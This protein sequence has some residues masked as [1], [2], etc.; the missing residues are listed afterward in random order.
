MIDRYATEEMKKIWNNENKYRVWLKVEL[1]VLKAY[2]EKGIIPKD[3]YL[4]IEKRAK[5]DAKRIDELEA[6]TRHDVI[7]FT[8]AVGENLGAEGRWFHYGLTSTDVVDTANALM[9]KEANILIEKELWR[10]INI[11]KEK[12]LAY[13][14]TPCIG[15]THGIHAEVT[16]FGLKWALW[17]DEALRDLRRFREARLEV[18]RGKLSGAVGN[19][20]NIDPE[21]E[22]TVCADLGIGYA[23]ISTQVLS[24][25]LHINYLHSLALIAGLLEKIATEIRHL[26]RT[27]IREAEE[28]FAPAQ[29]GS[30]AMPHKRNPIASENICGLSRVIRG[31]LFAAYECNALWH[32]RDISHSSVERIAIP[33]A[34]S[35]IHYMLR[36][37]AGV[38]DNLLVY[39]EQ[40]MKNIKLTNG[41]IFS[42]SVVSMMIE[43]GFSREESYDFIQKIALRAYA[44]NIDFLELLLESD[45]VKR[46]EP[47]EIKA[48][49][50]LDYYLR[51]ID[52]IYQRLKLEDE[53]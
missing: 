44:E 4:K 47:E 52:K 37:Y 5:I 24:R 25:D 53:K 2:A 34:S 30:S 16:S 20:A 32:E 26:S 40:M 19:F 7:A 29:K 42:G 11:L 28:Y 18:E 23:R 15:R 43:K 31:Y 36:R 12:A 22:K 1:A 33:D 35:L 46:F 8:R 49:F 13:K 14:N 50:N 27:E 41:V 3:D 39:P 17:Y 38:L 6:E 9:L 48:R 45:L 21:I 51:N 10:L